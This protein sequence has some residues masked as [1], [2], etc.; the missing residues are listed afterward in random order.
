MRVCIKEI[1]QM[2]AFGAGRAAR[3]SFWPLIPARREL[4]QQGLEAGVVTDELEVGVLA[5]KIRCK[6]R[7]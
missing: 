5:R 4:V 3:P 2:R 1:A 6:D 7:R